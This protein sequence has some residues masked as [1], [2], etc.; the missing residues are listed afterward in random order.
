[1]SSDE[2]YV[3]THTKQV[4]T[5]EDFRKMLITTP[6]IMIKKFFTNII[7]SQVQMLE[8]MPTKFDDEYTTIGTLYSSMGEYTKYDDTIKIVYP[9]KGITLLHYLTFHLND[10]QESCDIIE[11]VAHVMKLDVNE[12]HFVPYDL[13]SYG[14]CD[15]LREF[16]KE[17]GYLENGITPIH[18]ASSLG[19]YYHVKAFLNL[20]ANINI[21]TAIKHK[22]PEGRGNYLYYPKV[23]FKCQSL[24]EETNETCERVWTN[25][26]HMG[27]TIESDAFSLYK[28]F[29]GMWYA[30]MFGKLKG[31]VI[32]MI[33]TKTNQIVELVE[34]YKSENTLEEPVYIN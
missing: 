27:G 25:L 33:K 8:S 1:M 34:K 4:K 29:N 15:N 9:L 23:M 18:Y 19:K 22:S 12:K 26:T 24:K 7:V 20:K 14:Y 31:D 2:V 10:S 32:D 21:K 17:H 3:Y 28:N 16:Q 30:Y 6:L 11:F 13:T 5:C